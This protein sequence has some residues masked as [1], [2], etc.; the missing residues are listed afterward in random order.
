MVEV[1]DVRVVGWPRAPLQATHAV[2][3]PPLR[4]HVSFDEAPLQAVVAGGRQPLPVDMHLRLGAPEAVPLCVTVCEPLCIDSDYA[5]SIE[6]FDRAVASIRVRG[7]TRL[8]PCRQE[9]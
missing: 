4:A 5:V 8:A 2:A 9:F 1:A 3:E 7:R 6:I